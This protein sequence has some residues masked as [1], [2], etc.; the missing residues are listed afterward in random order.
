MKNEFRWAIAPR[1]F[2][3][4]QREL[5]D[6]P[7]PVKKSGVRELCCIV[8]HPGCSRSM[9]LVP[10]KGLTPLC[11]FTYTLACPS[12]FL[13]FSLLVPGTWIT[14]LPLC[15]T[16][17]ILQF[18]WADSVDC[19]HLKTSPA[20]SPLSTTHQLNWDL[21]TKLHSNKPP[22]LPKVDHVRD[23]DIKSR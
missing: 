2:L 3:K 10:F 5:S 13:P 11:Q 16:G 1:C 6:L 19:C 7:C 14:G 12:Q 9:G 21:Y 20:V 8:L 18:R 4:K 23:L 22:D 15:T 17:P